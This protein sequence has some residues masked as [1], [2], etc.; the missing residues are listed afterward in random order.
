MH[1]AICIVGFRNE[2]DI[3]ACLEA[4]ALST[5]A[6]FQV[7]VCENG[8]RA[9]YDRLLARVPKRLPGGQPVRVQLAPGN[10]GYAGGI[11]ACM[12]GSPD[13]DAWWVL[14][15]DTLPDPDALSEL[16]K[17]LSTGR[18]DVVGGIIY[19]ETGSVGSYGGRWRKWLARAE[20]IGLGRKLSD[21]VDAASVETELGYISGC[22]ML[23]G[24]RFV[25]ETGL[26]REDYFLY[27]EEVE[28]NLRGLRKGMR[29]GFAPAAR[30]FHKQGTTTGAGAAI[31]ERKKL[32]IY[33]DERNKMLL[34]RDLFPGRLPVAAGAAMALILLRFGR[35]GAWRQ[36]GYAAQGWAAGLLNRRG[37]PEWLAQD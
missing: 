18:H 25:E 36:L 12:H 37:V 26:M 7:V 24:R 16:V 15:P 20:S 3:A 35:R 29:L 5:Y 31:R 2:D 10:L 23:V 30:V 27:C 9:A 32:P 4:L 14:N 1:V 13:A 11:N 6:D 19:D 34:T 33:L 8:G 22:S 17:A 21:P 28:W